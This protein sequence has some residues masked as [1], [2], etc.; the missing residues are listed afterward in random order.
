MGVILDILASM[1]I[2]GMVVLVMLNVNFSLHN[3]LFQKS[4]HAVVSM[5]L[6]STSIWMERDIKRIGLNTT[7]VPFLIADDSQ[8]QFLADVDGNG[9]ADTVRYYL[10]STSELSGTDNP[11]DRKIY[12]VLDSQQPFDFAM[13][14]VKM[15]FQ[16][17]DINGIPTT[18]LGQIRSISVDLEMENGLA[19]NG[20]YPSSYWQCH[21]FPPN[22]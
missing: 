10:G 3:L 8:V 9:N 7:A 15:E 16:Y 5:N 17:F 21:I 20:I 18:N 12:R 11:T 14:V 2:R 1:G 13:G 19:Y 4:S 22:I 6:D